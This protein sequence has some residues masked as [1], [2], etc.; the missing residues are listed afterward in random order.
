MTQRQ[1]EDEQPLLDVNHHD[2]DAED[3]ALDSDGGED[4]RDT[5]VVDERFNPPPPSPWKR[6]ALLL[7]IVFL[8][9]IAFQM[10]SSI[11]SKKAKVVYASRYSKEHKFRPAASP[12]ITEA[13]KDGRTRLRGAYP[14]SA[15]TATPTTTARKKRRSGKFSGKA[16]QK[17]G[18]IP[19][20]Q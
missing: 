16:K 8:F 1:A 7:F 20:R 3:R 19:A 13:L 18:R 2:E 11:P 17:K 15:S 5:T 4:N 12:I 6:L 9:Y 10:R 14:T